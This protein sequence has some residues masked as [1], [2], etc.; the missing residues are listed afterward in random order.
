[1]ASSAVEI[2]QGLDLSENVLKA[3]GKRG[4]RVVEFGVSE[5]SST[6]LGSIRLGDLG[7]SSR[8]RQSM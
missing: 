5:G 6:S 8:K 3:G 4:K 2:S 1:M 7:M